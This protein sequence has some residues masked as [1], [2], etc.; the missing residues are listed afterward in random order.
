[1]NTIPKEVLANKS[2]RFINFCIDF[3][4]R[5][6]IFLGIGFIVGIADQFLM[7]NYV[8]SLENMNRLQEIF[9]ELLLVSVYYLLM[10]ILTARTI[11]KFITGT[12]VVD[13]YGN[14]ASSQH[15]VMRT[16]CRFVPFDPLSFLGEDGKGWHDKW[17]QTLVV[18]V[19]KFNEDKRRRHEF[20]E[21]GVSE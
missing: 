9:I 1:M 6:F 2:Q 10:E 5:I 15:I 14:K 3:I 19:K 17:S 16:L 13:Y 11:G 20:D 18:D 8:S 21:L 12:M 7:T 4:V